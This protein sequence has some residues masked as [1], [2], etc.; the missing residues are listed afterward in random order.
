M[1]AALGLI[2]LSAVAETPTPTTK[3]TVPKKPS[4]VTPAPTLPSHYAG[5]I[6]TLPSGVTVNVT[7]FPSG[8]LPSGPLNPTT[9]T[10]KGSTLL[11]VGVTPT[12]IPVI[13]PGLPP[14]IPPKTLSA[15]EVAA[16]QAAAI[17]VGSNPVRAA[18]QA[19]ASARSGV[20]YYNQT[21]QVKNADGSI[22]VYAVNPNGTLG[23]KII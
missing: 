15:S 4:V 3:K 19:Q 12:E 7:G 9:P 6:Q 17:S 14:I 1:L 8:V 23:A 21:K 13:N 18:V 16:V 22:S 20:P 2:A 5:E 11:G 10:F